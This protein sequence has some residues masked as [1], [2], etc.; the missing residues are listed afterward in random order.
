MIVKEFRIVLPMTVDEYQIAQLYSVAK[1][2]K[3]E[4]GGGDGV[5]IIRNEPF[6]STTGIQPVTPL[7]NGE[8]TNGQFTH[9]I[10]HIAS[11]V[12]GFIRWLAPKGS[13]EV[14]EEAW[15]AF[16]YCRTVLT[17]PGY[18]K[19]NFLIKIESI[20][21][22]DRGETENAHGLDELT[23]KKRSIVI[24]DIANDLV[25]P[26]DI[27]Q[28]IDP[29]TYKSVKT[30]R[31]PLIGPDWQKT[32][33]PVMCCYKLVTAEF[34][35]YGLQDRVENIIF[36]GEKRL[37]FKFHRELFCWT[38][39]WYGLTLNDIRILEEKTKKELDDQRNTGVVRG[40]MEESH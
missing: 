1:A 33:Q 35:W 37:F 32:C 2:S 11:K 18:M 27:N 36:N 6:T 31:G 16:P 29:T 26:R 40:M 9:K 38:D 28:N 25:D 22:P 3:D 15:N 7:C 13:L 12:P 4:T 34:K 14:A 5:E 39:E 19:K 10:Y 24:I 21:L 17:N 23:L 8:Y 20:H 30:G